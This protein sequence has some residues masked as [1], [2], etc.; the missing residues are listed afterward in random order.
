MPARSRIRPPVIGPNVVRGRI[1]GEAAVHLAGFGLVSNIERI[2]A[3]HQ[4]SALRSWT[5]TCVL[6]PIPYSG[7]VIHSA[8]DGGRGTAFRITFAYSS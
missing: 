2:G 6:H 3:L 5:R 7:V 1:E 4:R 8:C